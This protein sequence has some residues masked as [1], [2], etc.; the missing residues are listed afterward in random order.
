MNPREIPQ[1]FVWTKIQA[2]SGQTINQS[3]GEK[4]LSAKSEVHSGGASANQKGG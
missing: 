2:N 3:F 1:Y 4:N